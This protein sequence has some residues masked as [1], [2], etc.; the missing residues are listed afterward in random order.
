MTSCH[1]MGFA[2]SV[3]YGASCREGNKE[4]GKKYAVNAES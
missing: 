1:A 3:A 4:K 2:S